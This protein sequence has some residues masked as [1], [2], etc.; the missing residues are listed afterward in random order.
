MARAGDYYTS[1]AVHPAFGALLAVQ[2]F[3]MWQ[4]MEEPSD[5]TVVEMGAGN[6]LLA[7]D[8]LACAD[9]ISDEFARSMRYVCIDRYGSQLFRV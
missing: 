5:F 2:L 1:P 8:I 3:R 9:G 6:G 4:L 7:D